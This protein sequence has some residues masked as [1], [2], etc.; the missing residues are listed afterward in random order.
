LI[1]PWGR[2]QLRL[3]I[4]FELRTPRLPCPSL[5]INRNFLFVGTFLLLAIGM[6]VNSVPQAYAAA[7]FINGVSSSNQ[8][9]ASAHSFTTDNNVY[10]YVTV[11]GGGGAGPAFRLYVVSSPCCTNGQALADVAGGFKPESGI[12]SNTNY[13][14]WTAPLSVGT[15][16]VVADTDSSGTFTTGDQIDPSSFSVVSVTT[17]TA[18][19]TETTT[20]ILTSTVY[21]PTT[22]LTTTVYSPTTF[23]TSTVYSPTTYLTSTTITTLSSTVYSPTVTLTSTVYSPTVTSTSYSPT[24]TL[25]TTT[26]TTTTPVRTASVIVLVTDTVTSTSGRTAIKLV[27][28]TVTST[29]TATL[30]QLTTV[31]STSTRT[32]MLIPVFVSEALS[33]QLWT[34][35]LSAVWLGGL[36]VTYIQL[37]RRR[38]WISV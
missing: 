19:V 25:T 7:H 8:D 24:V 31:T 17:G 21:S 18:T 2:K 4:E 33:S 22:F 32:A 23:L 15:Y 30:V 20:T 13:L 37:R 1:S 36:A 9:G 26:T 35:I 5:K 38:D 27:T 10:A 16:Y 6:I 11:G 14:V 3:V 12:S 28:T 29:K 34:S